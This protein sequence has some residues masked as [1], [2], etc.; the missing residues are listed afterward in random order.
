MLSGEN[1]LGLASKLTST[2]RLSP[3][4]DLD[5]SWQRIEY[6][7]FLNLCFECGKV[8]Y[9]KEDCYVIL[10]SSSILVAMG[11]ALVIYVAH[12]TIPQVQDSLSADV[13]GPGLPTLAN[14][15]RS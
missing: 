1:L 4:V 7:N 9:Y 6:E 2:N 15:V 3:S 11:E 8:G 5:R 12:P 10:Q 14:H 13:F